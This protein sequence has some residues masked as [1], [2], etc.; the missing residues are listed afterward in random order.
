MRSLALLTLL[1]PLAAP[2]QMPTPPTPPAPPAVAPPATPDTSGMKGAIKAKADTAIDTGQG[3]AAAKTEE[4]GS[5]ADARVDA[6]K[7][8]VDDKAGAM[9]MGDQV[10][11]ATETGATKAKTHRK[12]AQA[13]AKTKTDA[14]SGKAHDKVN[15]LAK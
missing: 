3:A 2:A 12:K 10:K 13:G 8:K 5:K 7:A 9:P 11:S 1:V 14:T 6:A 15:E 4:V